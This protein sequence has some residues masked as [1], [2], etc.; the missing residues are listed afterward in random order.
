MEYWNRLP[1]WLRLGVIGTGLFL[2]GAALAFG[3]S[4]RPLHGALAWQ[5]DQLETRLDERNQE[6]LSLSDELAAL[7]SNESERIEPET[8]A[9]VERELE[10]TKRVLAQAEKD[11]AYLKTKHRNAEASATKWRKRYEQL[12]AAA[13]PEPP[14][15]VASPAP[16]PMPA[17]PAPAGRRSQESAESGM[18]GV[19]D[20]APLDSPPAP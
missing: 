20:G 9:Q 8:L 3:Y 5:V 1:S 19:G 15:P 18:L 12:L 6:I 7:R 16:E 11:V 10:Q 14:Q 2:A 4:Y 13:P 17:A